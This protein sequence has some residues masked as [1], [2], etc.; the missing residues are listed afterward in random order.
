MARS[1]AR[2]EGVLREL[3]RELVR[4]QGL[5]RELGPLAWEPHLEVD[6]M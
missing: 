2:P 4:L 1:P 6:R 3:R 5:P